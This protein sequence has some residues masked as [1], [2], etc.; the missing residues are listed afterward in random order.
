VFTQQSERSPTLGRRDA[1]TA[2]FARDRRSEYTDQICR[3]LTFVE[4]GGKILPDT[5][6]DL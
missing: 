3:A 4:T 1:Q 5:I 2:A 6:S